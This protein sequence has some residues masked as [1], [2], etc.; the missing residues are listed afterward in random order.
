MAHIKR[1]EEFRA[2]KKSEPI[3]ELFNSKEKDASKKALEDKMKEF[4]DKGFE[5]NAELLMKKAEEN[6]FRGEL[7]AV[8]SKKSGKVMVIYKDGLTN[9]QKIASAKRESFDTMDEEEEILNNEEE[10]EEDEF[11][12]IEEEEE[13]D[14]DEYEID[15]L[16]DLDSS[17]EIEE[18]F[19]EFDGDDED[20]EA[21]HEFFKS[22][23]KKEELE[24]SKKEVEAALAK[25]DGKDVVLDKDF[26]LKAAEENS[27]R[28]EV[29]HRKS[30][31][32]G[33][34]HVFYKDGLTKLQ[35]LATTASGVKG[36]AI[37]R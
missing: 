14:C 22:K 4:Q 21:V 17:E 20:P 23:S 15:N 3:N 9:L 30:K 27:Y 34:Y 19:E 37:N 8:K 12:A 2:N 11:E 32:D 25:Y 36:Q 5:V 7:K 26:I 28:G 31:K 13:F 1:F 10:T 29:L 24:K 16:E 18:E 33:K 35:K 6:K